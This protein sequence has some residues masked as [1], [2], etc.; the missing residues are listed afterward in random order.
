MENKEDYKDEEKKQE[1]TVI[2]QLDKDCA[3]DDEEDIGEE[4]IV[5]QHDQR[6]EAYKFNIKNTNLR[7]CVG[8][9]TTK[10]MD[11]H[12]NKIT[13][14]G[15]ATVFKID[16]GYAYAITAAHTLRKSIYFCAKCNNTSYDQQCG[17]C[18]TKESSVRSILK[19]KKVYFER[20]NDKTAEFEAK[21]NC[22]LDDISI[23]D[24]Q[25]ERF[26]FAA[27]GYDIAIVQFKDDGYYNNICQNILL[28]DGKKIH[29]IQKVQQNRIPYF[30]FGYPGYIEKK[31]NYQLFGGESISDLFECKRNKYG[32]FFLKQ[33]EIDTSVGMSGAAIFSV[34]KGV[35]NIYYTVIFGIHTGGK[36][37]QYNV[38]TLLDKNINYLQA[39]NMNPTHIKSMNDIT[40]NVVARIAKYKSMKKPKWSF[41]GTLNQIFNNNDLKSIISKWSIQKTLNHLSCAVDMNNIDKNNA[42]LKELCQHLRRLAKDNGNRVEILQYEGIDILFNIMQQ[43]SNDIQFQIYACNAI[44]N[45]CNGNASAQYPATV[46]GIYQFYQSIESNLDNKQLVISTFQA[47]C[48]FCGHNNVHISMVLA[49]DMIDQIIKTMKYY[50]EIGKDYEI[51]K[52]ACLALTNIAR[53]QQGKLSIGSKGIHSIINGVTKYKNKYMKEIGA[54]SMHVLF[55]LCVIPSNCECVVANGGIDL[56]F[57]ILVKSSIDQSMYVVIL[58]ILGRLLLYL[59]KSNKVK[60]IQILIEKGLLSILKQTMN[61]NSKQLREASTFILCNISDTSTYFAQ[62]IVDL[63][64]QTINICNNNATLCILDYSVSVWVDV[65]DVYKNQN[66]LIENGIMI[67]LTSNW[68]KQ[69]SISDRSIKNGFVLYQRLFSNKDNVK[70]LKPYYDKV[71]EF[72]NYCRQNKPQFVKDSNVIELLTKDWEN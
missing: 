51:H 13:E 62:Q 36:P 66:R 10:F 59:P 57:E 49:T 30:I 70:I 14:I 20:R 6:E 17:K 31:A 68:Y 9:L 32:R 50:G 24:T 2:D 48:N 18:N 63:A 43:I 44:S 11:K 38:G 23:N 16:M 61:N 1:Q 4:A 56:L 22:I 55:N 40:A 35:K 33:R 8:R 15:T 28:V 71:M 12:N 5:N 47:I 39:V 46:N 54:I 72:C 27:S 67:F 37:N 19:A 58:E 41:G 7:H 26:P 64:I 29:E 52:V 65:C 34:I 45:I 42:K 53:V 3:S 25:Y 69:P 60:V 21:Y